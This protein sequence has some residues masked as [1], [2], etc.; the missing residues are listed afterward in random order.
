MIS[1][2]ELYRLLA[3]AIEEEL[4]SL[5]NSLT[6]GYAQTYDAYKEMVGRIESLRKVQDLMQ[7][8]VKKLNG[9]DNA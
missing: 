7:E 6:G 8:T 1:D 9:A 2:G 4:D 3:D 5:C